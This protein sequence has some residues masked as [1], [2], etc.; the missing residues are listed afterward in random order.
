MVFNGKRTYTTTK[1]HVLT[2]FDSNTAR[3]FEHDQRPLCKALVEG[4]MLLLSLKCG[5]GGKKKKGQHDPNEA[6]TR[7][8]APMHKSRLPSGAADR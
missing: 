6:N 3:N 8:S 2:H 5:V 7:Q 1:W 4:G